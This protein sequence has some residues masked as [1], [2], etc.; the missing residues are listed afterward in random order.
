MLTEEPGAL[1]PGA[2]FLS[3]VETKLLPSRKSDMLY[4]VKRFEKPP[5]RMMMGTTG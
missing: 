5:H 4:N 2:L 1:A 3:V